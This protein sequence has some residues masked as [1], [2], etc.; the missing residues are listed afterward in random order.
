MSSVRK[1]K[2]PKG[3]ATSLSGLDTGR[4]HDGSNRLLNERMMLTGADRDAFLAAI[5]REGDPAPRLVEAL[6]RHRQLFG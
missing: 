6:K 3:K 2:S 5:D 4:A 1:K